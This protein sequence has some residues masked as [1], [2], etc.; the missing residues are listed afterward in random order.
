MRDIIPKHQHSITDTPVHTCAK[1]RADGTATAK[2]SGPPLA[3]KVKNVYALGRLRPN[4]VRLQLCLQ[5]VEVARLCSPEIHEA[6]RRCTGA[7]V[8]C[9]RYNRPEKEFYAVRFC[10]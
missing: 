1:A 2:R 10:L 5:T 8:F 9:L 4:D 7:A 6:I 3:G